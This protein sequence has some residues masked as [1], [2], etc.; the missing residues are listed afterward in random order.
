[1]IS[2][3]CSVFKAS[4]YVWIMHNFHNLP[5]WVQILLVLLLLLGIAVSVHEF[6]VKLPQII[7]NRRERKNQ[8]KIKLREIAENKKEITKTA[9]CMKCNTTIEGGKKLCTSCGTDEFID[10]RY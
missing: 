7:R 3:I 2:T 9:F 1:M 10:E 6:A 4:I 5:H 8:E